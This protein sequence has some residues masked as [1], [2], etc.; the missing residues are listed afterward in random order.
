MRMMSEVPVATVLPES[1]PRPRGYSN[2]LRVPA[3]RDLLFLAGQ[4]GWDE[5]EQL[6]GPDFVSQFEQ[7]LRNVVA[8]VE[9]AGGQV[10][11]VV[12]LTI[13]CKSKHEYLDEQR[14]V[15]EAY[16]RVMGSHYPCMSLL[17]VRDLVEEGAVVEVEATAALVPQAGE[18][19]S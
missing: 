9:A 18:G 7:A 14:A 17:E 4:I 8:V 3:G 15:G 10:A 1:W 5:H 12:R 19:A 2:G 6:V 11:D 16:R 13:F